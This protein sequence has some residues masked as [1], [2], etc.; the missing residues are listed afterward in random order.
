M[1]GTHT[2][3]TPHLLRKTC[4]Y[5]KALTTLTWWLINHNKHITHIVEQL[6][7]QEKDTCIAIWLASVDSTRLLR[8][9]SKDNLNL[10]LSVPLVTSL[11][12]GRMCPMELAKLN[13]VS[14]RLNT[15]SQM[16]CPVFTG[17]VDPWWNRIYSWMWAAPIFPISRSTLLSK[18]EAANNINLGPGTG[19][20]CLMGWHL[21]KNGSKVINFIHCSHPKIGLKSFLTWQKWCVFI[22]PCYNTKVGPSGSN[23]SNRFCIIMS[24]SCCCKTFQG[25]KFSLQKLIFRAGSCRWIDKMVKNEF[26]I[27]L[28]NARRYKIN[29]QCSHFVSI[30]MLAMMLDALCFIDTTSQANHLLFVSVFDMNQYGGIFLF[31]CFSAQMMHPVIASIN[32]TD[33]I[34]QPKINTTIPTSS[35]CHINHWLTQ[36]TPFIYTHSTTP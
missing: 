28:F 26:F 7:N 9:T 17:P 6:Q 25:H 35:C 19:Q 13:P 21:R 32:L 23:Q 4:K 3:A 11:Y 27:L 33:T 1:P 16:E 29:P 18:E 36:Y 10:Q 14:L 2:T 22:R 15:W 5:I 24:H 8:I 12:Q 34:H 20:S 30:R 31:L